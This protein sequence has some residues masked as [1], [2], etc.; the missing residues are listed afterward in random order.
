MPVAQEI[1]E[2]VFQAATSWCNLPCNGV[3]VCAPCG[4]TERCRQEPWRPCKFVLYSS[5]LSNH[6]AEMQT[7]FVCK[8]E[9]SEWVTFSTFSALYGAQLWG[10]VCYDK[11]WSWLRESSAGWTV[12]R[13]WSLQCVYRLHHIPGYLYAVCILFYRFILH[14]L[15]CYYVCTHLH[16]WRGINLK[17]QL[18]WQF[19]GRYVSTASC[20]VCHGN[21]RR[22]LPVY[23]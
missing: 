8:G 11:I 21:W 12:I 13:C 1:S 14:H 9:G 23:G 10:C 16:M 4:S 2:Y 20:T 5:L 15:H 17:W 3:V 7:W 18:L 22:H 6:P 19:A